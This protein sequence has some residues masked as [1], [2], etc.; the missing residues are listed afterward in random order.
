MFRWDRGAI[1]GGLVIYVKD[2]YHCTRRSDLGSIS[3]K[4]ICLEIK[5]QPLVLCYC[6]RPQSCNVSWL[7]DFSDSMEKCFLQQKECIILGDFNFDILKSV[8]SSRVWLELM[9]SFNY[10]QLGDK[11]TRISQ[12]SS[13]LIDHIFSNAPNNI[14]SISVPQYSISDHLPVCLT[15][16]T[17]NLSDKGSA[18]KYI[19]YRTI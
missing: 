16:T 6:Y 9:E 18:N 5:Q 8:G 2:I 17:Q 12:H 15:G 19:R 3:L 4:C 1:G 7:S 14:S 11:P 13:T 10:S